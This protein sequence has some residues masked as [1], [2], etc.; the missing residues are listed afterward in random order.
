M[1]LLLASLFPSRSFFNGGQI[2]RRFRQ[3]KISSVI[4]ALAVATGLGAAAVVA[5]APSQSIARAPV[6]PAPSPQTQASTPT[7]SSA[8]GTSPAPVSAAPPAATTQP[9]VAGAATRPTTPAPKAPTLSSAPAPTPAPQT[10][11]TL[12][13]SIQGR[14]SSFQLALT[15]GMDACTVLEKAEAEG[16]IASVTLD[17]SYMPTLRSAYVREI[18]G[19]ENNWTVKVNGVSPRG[20]SLVNLKSG[21]NVTWRFQ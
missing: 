16:K 17:Y 14:E 13:L 15:S 5:T 3:L 1:A 4:I 19:Y 21:D 12:A 2:V 20:C 9:T 18:N 6:T 8:I 7:Q 11:I 10:L